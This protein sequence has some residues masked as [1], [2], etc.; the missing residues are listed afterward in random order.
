MENVKSNVIICS[1]CGYPIHEKVEADLKTGEPMCEH[2]YLEHFSFCSCCDEP[3]AIEDMEHVDGYG[4]VCADCLAESFKKCDDCGLYTLKGQLAKVVGE[5]GETM[6]VCIDCLENSYLYCDGCGEYHPASQMFWDGDTDCYYCGECYEEHRDDYLVMGYHDFNDWELH[7]VNSKNEGIM[8]GF[9][10]EIEDAD[11][12]DDARTVNSYM[13]GF[14]VME[15]DGS[16]DNGF[17]IISH[18]FTTEY[19]NTYRGKSFE[20]MLKALYE[21]GCTSGENDSGLHIHVSR[22]CLTY[23]TALSEDEVI[24]NIIMIM[25]S[26]RNELMKFSRRTEEKMNNWAAFISSKKSDFELSYKYIK[27]NKHGSRYRALNLTNS[28]TIEFRIFNGTLNFRDFMAS[29]EL[30]DNIVEIARKGNIDGLT[31][32]DIVT[33]G[34]VYIA[35]YVNDYRIFSDAVLHIVESSD[36]KYGLLNGG[37]KGKIAYLNDCVEVGTNNV[38]PEVVLAIGRN[39]RGDYLV[40]NPEIR[41]HSGS[42][43]VGG[44]YTGTI[45]QDHLWWINP[46]KITLTDID[47]YPV[48]SNE[49]N[50]IGFEICD[51]NS[52]GANNLVYLGSDFEGHS[53]GF[54]NC[55]FVNGTP[56]EKHCWWFYDYELKKFN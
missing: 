23:N 35:D 44:M 15:E 56:M 16:L 55:E 25:E 7:Y 31:W 39:L 6:H 19:F 46:A 11:T 2:C 21:N 12:R 8:K 30:V 1:V 43:L 48:Y 29:I 28:K 10:L 51:D 41:G 3:H 34:G 49:F 17:E 5:E 13:D 47:A 42:S 32:D 20:K 37:V 50:R 52:G 14:V 54:V 40:Y 26:F 45:A 36:E 22:E 4:Y 33:H 38:H 27:A 53:G 9:E 24:D 18:P